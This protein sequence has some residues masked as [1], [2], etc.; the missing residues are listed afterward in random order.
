MH[1]L[2]IPTWKVW[3]ESSGISRLSSTLLVHIK[4]KNILGYMKALQK[5]KERRTEGRKKEWSKGKRK[6][7]RE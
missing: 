3:T 7:G 2:V 6:G 1:T 5:R 4:L